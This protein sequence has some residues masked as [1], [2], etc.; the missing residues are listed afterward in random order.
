[1]ASSWACDGFLSNTFFLVISRLPAHGHSDHP[2]ALL[3]STDRFHVFQVYTHVLLQNGPW[4][5]HCDCHHPNPGLTYLAGVF[6]T[7]WH[8]DFI[9][10]IPWPLTT[11]NRVFDVIVHTSKNE[12]EKSTSLSGWPAVFPNSVIMLS[13]D[14]K[15]SRS[16]K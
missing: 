13:N 8:R 2:E 6:G 5:G 12:S 15:S 10:T 3:L 1:M 4:H 7:S 11:G 9:E 16:G 14:R